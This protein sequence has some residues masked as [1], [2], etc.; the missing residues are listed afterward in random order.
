MIRRISGRHCWPADSSSARFDCRS[1]NKSTRHATSHTRSTISVRFRSPFP[2]RMPHSLGASFSA[3]LE[4]PLAASHFAFASCRFSLSRSATAFFRASSSF[5]RCSRP[6]S[7]SSSSSN[8][9]SL[10]SLSS[11]VWPPPPSPSSSSSSFSS[12]S[13]SSS[14][15]LS[16]SGSFSAPWPPNWSVPWSA[17]SSTSTTEPRAGTSGVLAVATT[18]GPVRGCWAGQETS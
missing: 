18:R 4:R 11:S 9:S 16:L 10:S 15:S 5:F 3:G 17:P 12:S 14:S 7:S 2:V 6:L 13:P 1:P 8:L